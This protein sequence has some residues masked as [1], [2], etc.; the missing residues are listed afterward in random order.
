M[1]SWRTSLG[2]IGVILSG[3]GATIKLWTQ[4]D[5]VGAIAAAIAAISAGSALIAARDNKVPSSAV[6]AAAKTDAAIKGDTDRIAKGD[7][8]P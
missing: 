8:A 3:F 4:G 5:L 7:S 6:P 1:K 2:G